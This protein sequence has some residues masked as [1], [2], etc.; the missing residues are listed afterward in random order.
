MTKL[1]TI[2][3]ALLLGN[4]LLGLPGHYGTGNSALAQALALTSVYPS[5]VEQLPTLPGWG[6][7]EATKLAIE[8]GIAWP[9]GTP[10]PARR[11]VVRFTIEPTGATDSLQIVRGVSAEA[12]AAVL[13]A[14]RRLPHFV[15]GRQGGRPVRVAYTLG[16]ALPS[17]PTGRALAQRLETQTREQGVAQRLP[18]EADT[19]FLRRVLPVSY[20]GSNDLVAYAWRLSAFGKQLFF[21]TRGGEANDGGTDLFVLDSYQ[22]NTYAVQVLPIQSMG[23]LT[24]LDALFFADANHDGR[25]DLLALASCSLKERIKSERI[26]IKEDGEWR[27]VHITHYRTDTWQCLGLDKTGRP[28]YEQS[29]ERPDLDDLATAAEVRKALALPP[30]PHRPAPAKAAARPAKATRYKS[31]GLLP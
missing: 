16:I 17:P 27:N 6:G 24:D 8:E 5:H 3:R 4:L 26:R 29:P 1:T 19:T 22:E 21:S 15:P 2:W 20:P 23:D 18:G 25:K 30:R 13:A 31:Q 28:Q 12:D 10:T 14:V 11:I 9:M 7:P